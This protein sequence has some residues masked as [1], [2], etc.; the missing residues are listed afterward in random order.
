MNTLSVPTITANNIPRAIVP[1]S[2][3]FTEGYG[4]TNVRSA[5]T[6][7]GSS[8]SVHSENGEN[9]NGKITIDMYVTQETRE[10]VAEAKGLTGA[11]VIQAV[12]AGLPP[13]TGNRMSLT[14]DPEFAASAD[15]VVTLEFAGDRLVRT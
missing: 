13:V 14:N 12:Q 7:G 4:E 11:N 6:G 15:G 8:E 3:K 2:F 10:F 5:S 9:N 1:N